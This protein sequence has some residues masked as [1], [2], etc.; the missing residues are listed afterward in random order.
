M[1]GWAHPHPSARGHFGDYTTTKNMIHKRT[2][3]S[4][5]IET[6]PVF[7]EARFLLHLLKSTHVHTPVQTNKHTKLLTHTKTHTLR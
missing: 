3:L 2:R 6:S 1:G 5:E 7:A 4:F